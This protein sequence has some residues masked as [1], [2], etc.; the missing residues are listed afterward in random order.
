[1]SKKVAKSRYWAFIMYP[2]SAP[3]DWKNILIRAALPIAIS[4]IHD[5]D[6]KNWDT[7][8][9]D[10]SHWHVLC[11]FDG[12]TTQANVIRISDS[13]NA[14]IPIQVFSVKG[15]YDYLVHPQDTC[16]TPYSEADRINLNGFDV[17]N[18]T[19]LTS[20]EEVIMVK[21]IIH[22]IKKEKI[23]EYSDLVDYAEGEDIQ[24]YDY[25]IHHTVFF[26][27]VLT[28]IR[29]KNGKKKKSIED[30]FLEID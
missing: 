7:G 18:Y 1:M 20:K 17:T 21:S 22:D 24:M 8:E 28:S 11:C 14:T 29:Q 6:V 12:P 23:C 30:K 4:P 25:V 16:K 15:Y 9:M 5:R 27:A 26:N 10:K 2:D 19:Q 13:V 3:E